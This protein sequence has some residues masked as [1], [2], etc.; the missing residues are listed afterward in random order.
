MS[1]PSVLVIGAGELGTAVLDALSKHAQRQSGRLAVLLREDTLKSADPAKADRNEYLRSLGIE[2]EA[3]DFINTPIPALAAVFG[4]YDVVIQC[5][6]YGI[7]TEVQVRVTEAVLEAGVPRYF[8]WQFGVDYDAI[9]PGNSEGLFDGML[10]VRQLLR[11]QTKTKWTIISVGMFMSY[12]FLP[13]FGIVD[14]EER[15][16][17]ALGSWENRVTVTTVEG[18]G[19]MTA[20]AVYRPDGTGSQVV[21]IAGDTM[22]YGKLAELLDSS[23]GVTFKR[24]VWDLPYL[25]QKLAERPEDLMAKYRVVFGSGTGI[26][27]DM[28]ETLNHQRGIH[29]T[30]IREYI[31]E[32]RGP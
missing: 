27:W 24:E 2:L 4:R 13:S 11:S 8:P 18:I 21:H 20:E 9:G 28:E 14:L 12:L 22:S 5:G 30:G 16:V 7:P 23:Y 1:S 32:N 17:R 31:E 26:S 19:T 3:G 10:G 25:R 6:G 15:T 29:L